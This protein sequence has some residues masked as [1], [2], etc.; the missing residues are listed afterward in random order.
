MLEFCPD[1]KEQFNHQTC[2][3]FGPYIESANNGVSCDLDICLLGTALRPQTHFIQITEKTLDSNNCCY[4]QPGLDLNQQPR[5]HILLLIPWAVHYPW[6]LLLMLCYVLLKYLIPDS[7]HR[8]MRIHMNNSSVHVA[9]Y[10]K[11]IQHKNIYFWEH[12]N[13][14]TFLENKNQLY[15]SQ[16]MIFCKPLPLPRKR[17][18]LDYLHLQHT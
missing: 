13:S 17:L 9:L 7:V 10:P 18:V 1:N 2:S 4:F 6:I 16:A 5:L 12:L 14:D 11:N 8:G 3:D 15:S